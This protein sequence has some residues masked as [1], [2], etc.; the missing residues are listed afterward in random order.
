M[1][2]IL[3]LESYGKQGWDSYWNKNNFKTTCLMPCSLGDKISKD[4]IP[5]HLIERRISY[6]EIN[7]I[8]SFYFPKTKF[9]LPARLAINIKRIINSL[10][11]KKVINKIEKDKGIK[12]DII[13]LHYCYGTDTPYFFK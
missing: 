11:L 1:N 13:L 7:K 9:F 8:I 4:K 3:E 6:S 5:I 2:N 10:I 12:F